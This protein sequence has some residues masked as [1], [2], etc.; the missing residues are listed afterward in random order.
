M[1]IYHYNPNTGEFLRD[2]E[3][4]KSPEDNKDGEGDDVYLVPAY[5]TTIEPPASG[6]DEVACYIDD[7]WQLCEDHRGKEVYHK[8]KDKVKRISELGAIPAR[9]TLDAKP[10]DE[11]E[12]DDN[13]RQ[14]KP[15][16][17]RRKAKRKENLKAELIGLNEKSVQW[18]RE[19]TV[20]QGTAP[21]QLADIENEYK[22]KLDEFSKL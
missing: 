20:A 4:R 10:D 9:Y 5:A 3:A 12:F 16:E 6:V 13:D 11:H 19:W 15:S 1:R 14:W 8:T 7:E 21:Q 17:K 22:D 18:I 2:A